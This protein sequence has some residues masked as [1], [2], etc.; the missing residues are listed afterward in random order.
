MEIPLRNDFFWTAVY[1]QA[2]KLLRD[3]GSKLLD[4][5]GVENF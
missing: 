4:I 1:L 5:P 3:G 2:R